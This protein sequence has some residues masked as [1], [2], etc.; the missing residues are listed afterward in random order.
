MI[1]HDNY[2][3]TAK[4]FR[5]CKKTVLLLDHAQNRLLIFK[6]PSQ[7]AHCEPSENH[8]IRPTE[9]KL[10]PFKDALFNAGYLALESALLLELWWSRFSES[11]VQMITMAQFST[12]G[13]AIICHFRERPW[14]IAI[15]HG[16]LSKTG[17]NFDFL[18]HHLII[19][20]ASG[21]D[22]VGCCSSYLGWLYTN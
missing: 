22:I 14:V 17:P 12:L 6:T 13:Q 15:A 16:I 2:D 3:L 18:R 1:G 5:Q 4:C 10:C 8:V 9:P 21:P 11:L 20:C 7:P 19:T